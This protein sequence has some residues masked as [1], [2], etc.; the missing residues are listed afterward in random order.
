MFD[1]PARPVIS[2]RRASNCGIALLVRV[3]TPP[4]A[5]AALGINVPKPEIACVLDSAPR[6][7][8][9]IS[10]RKNSTGCSRD[11]RLIL[12]VITPMTSS[13]FSL[14]KTVNQHHLSTTPCGRSLASWVCTATTRKMVEGMYVEVPGIEADTLDMQ[15]RFSSKR[16]RGR[17][18]LIFKVLS[19]GSV[20]FQPFYLS[21]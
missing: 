8:F 12:C 17:I 4:A 20:A 19:H 6:R 14:R 16:S 21:L 1:R 15:A 18:N 7:L 10:F 13:L 5:Q 11:C 2:S 3:L 9:S